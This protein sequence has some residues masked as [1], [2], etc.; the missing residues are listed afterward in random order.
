PP[1]FKSQLDI[2]LSDGLVQTAILQHWAHRIEIAFQSGAAKSALHDALIVGIDLEWYEHDANYITEIGISVL[3]PRYVTR[4]GSAWDVLRSMTTH[5]VRV[6]EHAHMINSDF[7]QGSPED[8]QFGKTSFVAVDE[9]KNVLRETFIQLDGR[10]PR[11]IIFVGHAVENDVAMTK[12]RFGFDIA[13]LET[14]AA[15]V[16]T[17]VLAAEYGVVQRP[18]KAKLSQVLEKLGISE[19]SLHNAGNDIVCTMIAALLM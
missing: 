1:D 8:F 16:D 17:Q 18:K 4:K 5:H 11:P 2:S 12:D 9:A 15:T 3:D 19:P 7:C 13:K 10:G 6:C 14:V